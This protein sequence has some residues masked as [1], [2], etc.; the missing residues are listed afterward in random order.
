MSEVT[1]TLKKSVGGKVVEVRRYA[2]DFPDVDP[3]EAGQIVA[4]AVQEM[5]EEHNAE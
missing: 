1:I 2:V 5:K 4:N 3:E